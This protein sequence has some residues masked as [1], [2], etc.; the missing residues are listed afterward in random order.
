MKFFDCFCGL[1]GAS[2]GFAREGFDCTG[3][4][5]NKDIAKLYPYEVIVADMLDLD[6]KDFQGY[7]VIWGSPPCR[8][9]CLFAKRFGKTWKQ[10][11]PNPE[12]GLK[13][14]NAFLR[15]VQEAKPKFW[16]MEN[17]PYLADYLKIKPVFTANLRRKRHMVRS[18]WGHFPQ[19]LLPR[20]NSLV[21]M[22]YRPECNEKQQVI[23]SREERG[24]FHFH[25]V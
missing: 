11:P 1:G 17:V 23:T 10:N 12:R 13:L 6:G 7:D 22:R 16:I 18:F 4:E 8:D 20:D 24:R 3:I 19:F 2:E 14:V 9:F 15:F 21:V 5:I 25:A